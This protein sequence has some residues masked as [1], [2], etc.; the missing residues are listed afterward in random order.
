MWKLGRKQI[1][2]ESNPLCFTC[3][4]PAAS[5]GHAVAAAVESCSPAA[6]CLCSPCQHGWD[7][8][9]AAT[10]AWMEVP[11]WL[12]MPGETDLCAAGRVSPGGH[13]QAGLPGE[14]SAMPE[15]CQA[16]PALLAGGGGL[17]GRGA[18]AAGKQ[19]PP[20]CVR[21]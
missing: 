20:R 11:R 21:P 19:L 12:P 9:W 3:L 1:K 15:G 10:F 8:T 17:G 7:M 2:E 13:C 4:E 14:G 16:A 6:A 18:N 5:P